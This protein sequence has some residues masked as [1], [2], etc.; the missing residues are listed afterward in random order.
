MINIVL[1]EHSGE[2]RGVHVVRRAESFRYYAMH[3]SDI[4]AFNPY[5]EE[6]GGVVSFY[7][8]SIF[9]LACGSPGF[10]VDSLQ[11]PEAMRA[12]GYWLSTA[13]WLAR[14][15][16]VCD[17]NDGAEFVFH[18]TGPGISERH[19]LGFVPSAQAT[20]AIRQADGAGVMV[21]TGAQGLIIAPFDMEALAVRGP[22]RINDDSR[23]A[24][25]L[26]VTPTETGWLVARGDIDA[27]GYG[28]TI[29]HVCA[30]NAD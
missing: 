6:A 20:L 14:R 13:A 28:L 27:A 16:A 9:A 26:Y 18:R 30:Q 22:R 25:R 17:D 19:E 11:L 8:Q 15:S 7:R 1:L 2:I 5:V 23:I 12:T 10:P 21:D 3:A 24:D 29:Q 4:R